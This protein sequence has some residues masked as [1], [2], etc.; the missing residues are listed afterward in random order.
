MLIEIITIFFI[1]SSIF[2]AFLKTKRHVKYYFKDNVTEY[3]GFVHSLL[4]I[5]MLDKLQ[6]FAPFPMKRESVCEDIIWLNRYAYL[7]IFAFI[8]SLI[9]MVLGM[10]ENGV[11]KVNGELI[12]G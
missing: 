10:L 11:L 1:F 7:T 6:V 8:M 4:K 3:N 5:N 12:G 9:F 2:F